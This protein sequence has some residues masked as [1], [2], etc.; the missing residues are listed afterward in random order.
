MASPRITNVIVDKTKN[1]KFFISPKNE[2]SLS[3]ID[4]FLS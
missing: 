3:L 2:F 4:L 1:F